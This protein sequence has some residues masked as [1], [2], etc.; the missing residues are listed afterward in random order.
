MMLRSVMSGLGRPPA[1]RAARLVTNDPCVSVFESRPAPSWKLPRLSSALV[2]VFVGGGVL[3]LIA[4]G[5]LWLG[6]GYASLG[7]LSPSVPIAH[8][9]VLVSR[10]WRRRRD[11]R[12]EGPGDR[13]ASHARD[14][15]SPQPAVRA[16]TATPA[17]TR[18][19]V[20]VL[21]PGAVVQRVPDPPG[22][23]VLAAPEHDSLDTSRMA[24]QVSE[25]ASTSAALRVPQRV[26][27]DRPVHG[28]ARRAAQ[29]SNTTAHAAN[30][31]SALGYV[32]LNTPDPAQPDRD[33]PGAAD[34]AIQALCDQR[35][36]ALIS[37]T[38]DVEGTGGNARARPALRWV[39]DQLAAGHAQT[40]VVARLADLSDTA[41][42]LSELLRWLDDQNRTL[43]AVDLGL[44]TSTESGQLA[45]EALVRVGGWE[46]E[47][48]SAG[49]RRGLAAARSRG[50]GGRTA[51]ADVPELMERVRRMRAEGMTLQGIADVLN[52]EGVPTLRGGA[53]WRP[54]SVQAAT[55][56]RRPS[57]RARRLDL[58]P[59]APQ[60]RTAKP[61]RP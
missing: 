50:A 48:I 44:D 4:G 14:T 52:A 60:Q 35:R 25:K 37:I 24:S 15:P 5:P 36:M 39:L 56:Y 7:L 16:R 22:R 33:E 1:K 2:A 31:T 49:T 41:A 43:I 9:S 57:S 19:A 54:S 13:V 26:S 18:A 53:K 12:E 3:A 38:R 29:R 6:I 46:H 59:G 23:E 28:H 61:N 34:R 32:F 42:T 30:E 45:A 21:W 10:G 17:T 55:G 51:V 8:R 20:G 27:T 47:R 11:G 58:P 40:L